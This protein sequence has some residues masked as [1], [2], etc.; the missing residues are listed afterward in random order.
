MRFKSGNTFAYGVSKWAVRG[1]TQ[2]AALELAHHDI[3]VSSKVLRCIQ[4]FVTWLIGTGQRQA[5]RSFVV[6]GQNTDDY[7]LQPI[8]LVQSTQ[9]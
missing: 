1:L 6:C 4:S 9:R 5:Q 3:N 8:A 2:S 7:V